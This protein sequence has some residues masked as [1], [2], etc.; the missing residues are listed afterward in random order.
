MKNIQELKNALSVIKS[1]MGMKIY[2]ICESSIYNK[3]CDIDDY[4][5][6][7]CLSLWETELSYRNIEYVGKS[8][9]FTKEEAK[10]RLKELK[11]ELKKNKVIRRRKR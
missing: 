9:L 10:N 7:N 5:C 4:N 2:E 8:V 3:G 11:N 6:D 1:C